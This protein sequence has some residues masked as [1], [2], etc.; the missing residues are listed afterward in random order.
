M[1]PLFSKR[2]IFA[3]DCNTLKTQRWQGLLMSPQTTPLHNSSHKTN[4]PF[5]STLLGQS[6]S[7][8]KT[9]YWPR[10]SLQTRWKKNFRWNFSWKSAAS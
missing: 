9:S 10:C 3:T 5:W 4:R 8:F 2:S 1:T 7:V 6:L